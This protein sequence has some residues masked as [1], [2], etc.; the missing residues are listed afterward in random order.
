[1]RSLMHRFALGAMA[2]IAFLGTLLLFDIGGLGS[3]LAHDRAVFV[4]VFMLVVDLCGLFGIVVMISSL[5]ED[6]T[7]RPSGRAHRRLSPNLG[8]PKAA[9]QPAA[10]QRCSNPQLLKTRR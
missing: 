7:D 10:L 9:E 8:I 1:M 5:S 4:P 2:G 3:L 6:E